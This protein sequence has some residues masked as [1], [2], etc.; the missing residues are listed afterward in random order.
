MPEGS[1]GDAHVRRLE[2]R[3]LIELVGDPHAIDVELYGLPE[4][5][6]LLKTPHSFRDEIKGLFKD[7]DCKGAKM[8]AKKTHGLMQFREHEVTVWFGYKSS[9]K[10]VF[11]NEL[12]TWWAS[13]GIVVAMASFE[14][15]A[16]KLAALAVRQALARE[17]PPDVEIDYA[18]DRLAE[19][20]VI[21]DVMGRVV[22]KHLLAVM[23]YCAVELGCQHFL[24][25]NLTDL[26]P[27]G[28]DHSDAHQ[29][30]FSGCLTV[31]RGTGMHVHVVAHTAKPEKGDMSKVPTGYNIR[32][33]GAVP[34]MADNC[35]AVWRNL[36]KEDKIDAGRAD[37]DTYKEPDVL[38]VVDKQKFWNF[39]GGLK[40]WLD[41]K[42]LRFREYGTSEAE[43]FV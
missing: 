16:Y 20:M 23:R 5:G 41:R 8:P 17:T 1:F 13:R 11:L 18:V 33:T 22:P 3:R 34:D 29:H 25:D 14:M 39:R 19:S 32:G 26:L 27:V 40:Y 4:D 9:F 38:L 15:P 35:L 28:N 12:F 36:P 37:A 21:Y 31:A 6:H 30:F 2:M 7:P 42:C 24:I 10:S 43:P